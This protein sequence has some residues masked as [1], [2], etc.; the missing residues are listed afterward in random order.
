MNESRSA[1][2]EHCN[3]VEKL[4]EAFLIWKASRDWL[5]VCHTADGIRMFYSVCLMQRPRSS[6]VRRFATA[7]WITGCRRVKFHSVKDDHEA[8]AAHREAIETDS[9]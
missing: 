8:S 7:W 6:G 3:A 1:P 2:D 9:K 5:I 4:P